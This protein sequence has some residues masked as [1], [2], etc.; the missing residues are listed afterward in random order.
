MVMGSGALNAELIDFSVPI[1]RIIG[2]GRGLPYCIYSFHMKDG[3]IIAIRLG[4][5]LK[6]F[7]KWVKIH[8]DYSKHESGKR[9]RKMGS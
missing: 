8:R 7:K 6:S 4:R 5:E 2:S 3:S 1:K 9:I